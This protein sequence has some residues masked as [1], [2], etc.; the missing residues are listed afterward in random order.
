MAT[1]SYIWNGPMCAVTLKSTS[2]DQDIIFIPGREVSL[3]EDNDYTR[4]L[5]SLGH[6]VAAPVAPVQQPAQ[7]G[8]DGGSTK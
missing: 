8:S 1:V 4:A 5:L 6:M 7:S 3:P 2:A